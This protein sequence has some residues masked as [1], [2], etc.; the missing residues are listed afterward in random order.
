[1]EAVVRYRP[2]A[3]VLDIKMPIMEGLEVIQRLRSDPD[4]S[5]AETP[6]VVLSATQVIQE[7][8][9]KFTNLRVHRW[10]AKPFDPEDLV[11]AVASALKERI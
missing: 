4:A 5:L 10:I 7:A 11:A 9:E 2:D 6:V 8:R 3:L 1:L